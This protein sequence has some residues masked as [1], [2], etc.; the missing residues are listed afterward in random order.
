MPEFA[1]FSKGFQG[2]GHAYIR[3]SRESHSSW[4]AAINE[5]SKSNA[6]RHKTPNHRMYIVACYLV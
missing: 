1:R 5:L 2:D 3:E 6:S 4:T